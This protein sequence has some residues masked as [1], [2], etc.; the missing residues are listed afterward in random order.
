MSRDRNSRFRGRKSNGNGGQK[1]ENQKSQKNRE[2]INSR[3]DHPEAVEKS[4]SHGN[5]QN[6]SGSHR[7]FHQGGHHQGGQNRGSARQ[8]YEFLHE[9]DEA[10]KIFKTENQSE[11]SICSQMITD[12]ASA[13]AGK[14]GASPVHFECAL[15][16]VQEG[17]KLEDGDKIAYIGQGRF[18]VLNYPNIHDI[19]HWS[20][21]K[22]IPWEDKDSQIRWRGQMAELYSRTK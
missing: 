9:N 16:T 15:K 2:S 20:I 6:H 7:N 13:L 4:A 3:N 12:L 19:K 10:I 8:N 5:Y 22:I 1:A 21:R 17:E 18:A 14:N 11:C